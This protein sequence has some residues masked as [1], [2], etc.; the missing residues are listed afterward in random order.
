MSLQ[1]V[2]QF[3]AEHTPDTEITELN[4]NTAAVALAAA[5]HNVEPG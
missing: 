1:F 5:V 3:F 4:Q 2:R